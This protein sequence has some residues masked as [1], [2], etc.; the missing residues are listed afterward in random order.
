MVLV[1]STIIII[2]ELRTFGMEAKA[3]KVDLID[4]IQ[5]A[6]DSQLKEIYGLI[7]NYFNGQDSIE[8]WDSLP[9]LHQKLI[10]KGLE[11]ADAGLTKPV[12]EVTARL[13]AKYGLNG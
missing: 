8:E 12:K 1:I 10:L 13:K 7:T 2:F 5:H 11:Q 4:I 6:D 9:E 3:I